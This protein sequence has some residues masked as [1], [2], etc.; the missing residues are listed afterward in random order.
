MNEAEFI[1][2]ALR[3]LD[4]AVS[5][6]EVDALGEAMLDQP[7]LRELYR[8]L[9]QQAQLTH[10]WEARHRQPSEHAKRAART[11]RPVAIAIELAAAAAAIITVSILLLRGMSP[12][13]PEATRTER[14]VPQAAGFFDDR[15]PSWSEIYRSP[16][17]YPDFV[18]RV[19]ISARGDGSSA[20]PDA[21]SEADT[22]PVIAAAP[23]TQFNRLLAPIALLPAGDTFDHLLE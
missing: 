7:A 17:D 2:L 1:E 16:F 5:Q 12:P 19:E 18:W 15:N 20:L 4:G 22:L 11:L 13:S 9:V 8:D 3:Y 14:P 10:E 21:F 23:T 6:I